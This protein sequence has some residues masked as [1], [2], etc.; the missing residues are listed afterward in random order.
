MPF[1]VRKCVTQR[2]M[3]Y[4]VGNVYSVRE[5][6]PAFGATPPPLDSLQGTRA[7]DRARLEARMRYVFQLIRARHPEPEVWSPPS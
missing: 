3:T 6:A 7:T 2:R 5:D 4:D 1:I